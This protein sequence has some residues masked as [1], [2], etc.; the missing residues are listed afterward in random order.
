M[1]TDGGKEN[2]PAHHD[3]QSNG[4]AGS[5]KGSETTCFLGVKPSARG[6]LAVGSSGSDSDGHLFRRRGEEEGVLSAG[7]A[8]RKGEPETL[9]VR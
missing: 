2:A 8:R 5:G 3:S 7:M 6:F 4:C 9:A 1:V